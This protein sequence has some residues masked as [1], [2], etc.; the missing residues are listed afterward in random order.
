M[1]LQD[2]FPLGWS[3][4]QFSPSNQ[5][6]CTKPPPLPPLS[7]KMKRMSGERHHKLEST[8]VGPR[9]DQGQPPPPLL[10]GFLDV[11]QEGLPQGSL[12]PPI[13]R[14]GTYLNLTVGLGVPIPSLARNPRTSFRGRGGGSLAMVGPSLLLSP[15]GE[16]C[17]QVRRF[18]L[19]A[20]DWALA[21]S[22]PQ[23]LGTASWPSG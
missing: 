6:D 14:T 13:P 15:R 17:I 5:V 18:M 22:M 21:Q 4:F 3:A 12:L 10:S 1:V 23:Q 7:A 8:S 11:H 19:G 20:I 9:P 2:D 16:H